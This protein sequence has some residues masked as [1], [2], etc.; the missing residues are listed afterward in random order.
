VPGCDLWLFDEQ[1]VMFNHFAGDGTWSGDGI[2]VRADE[3]LAKRFTDAFEAVWDRAIPHE[4]Y[5]PSRR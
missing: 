3:A 4:E 1:I 2:E 5:R